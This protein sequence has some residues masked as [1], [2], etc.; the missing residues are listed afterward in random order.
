MKLQYLSIFDSGRTAYKICAIMIGRWNFLAIVD[1][2][3]ENVR[4]EKLNCLNLPLFKY[5][6]LNKYTSEKGYI[7]GIHP[8]E[9]TTTCS[10]LGVIN[11]DEGGGL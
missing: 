1:S 6:Y 9:I 5:K 11:L 2:F 3:E 10:V 7:Y 8:W 4:I